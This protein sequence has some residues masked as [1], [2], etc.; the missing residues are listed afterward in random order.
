MGP[1]Q[2]KQNP[3]LVVVGEE[4][5]GDTKSALPFPTSSSME[6]VIECHWVS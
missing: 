5:A 1:K 6:N 4:E 2:R 3:K